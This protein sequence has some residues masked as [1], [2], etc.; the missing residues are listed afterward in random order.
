MTH[1]FPRCVLTSSDQ[2]LRERLVQ[3]TQL[4]FVNL[5]VACN[6]HP[7]TLKPSVK[8]RISHSSAPCM[9]VKIAKSVAVPRE[10]TTRTISPG[11]SFMLLAP[12]YLLLIGCRV[13]YP[14]GPS[15]YF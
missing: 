1:I 6:C 10:P 12:L 2:R 5:L 9:L 4:N 14:T 8:Q 11:L 13:V 15:I 7:T 3:S